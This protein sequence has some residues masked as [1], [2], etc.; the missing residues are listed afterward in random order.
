MEIRNE[1]GVTVIDEGD[2]RVQ[3]ESGQSVEVKIGKSG[4][5]LGDVQ[6]E[7]SGRAFDHDRPQVGP[8]SIA[9]AEATGTEEEAEAESK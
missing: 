4:A 2:E 5:K 3:L 8:E 6:G 1:G 9:E 7:A